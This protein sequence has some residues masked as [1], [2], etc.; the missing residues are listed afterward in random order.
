MQGKKKKKWWF[1]S[2]LCFRKDETQFCFLFFVFFSFYLFC[3]NAT[4]A[5]APRQLLPESEVRLRLTEE[6]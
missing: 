6:I 1:F 5:S 2:L 3:N 4:I